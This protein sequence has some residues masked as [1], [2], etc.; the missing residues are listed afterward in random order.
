[1]ENCYYRCK[2]LCTFELKDDMGFY[3]E[4]KVLAW[5]EAAAERVLTC[6]ECGA[7]VY[8]AAGTIKEPYFA[9][10]DLEDCDYGSGQESEELRK[11]KRLIYQLLRRSFP[12]YDIQARYRLEN[13][14][15]ASMFCTDGD[16]SIVIDY[17]LLNSS[18]Q[19][20]R[21]RDNYYQA[22][23]LTVVY[24]LGKRQQKDTKQLDW[25]QNLIQASAGCLA[26]LD[27]GEETLTLKRSIGYRL[28]KE[29]KFKY[30]VKSYKMAEVMLSDQGRFLCDFDEECHKI[31]AEAEQEK[32]LYQV[33]QDNL[34]RLQ[35]ERI[36][37][38]EQERKRME[39]YHKKQILEKAKKLTEAQI[40][41]MELNP[42]LF[43]KCVSM[44]E[45]GNGHLVAKKY[46]D[47]ING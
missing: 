32:H 14:M 42:A 35:E 29:R 3:Y 43:Y 36:Q 7:P 15:Y 28:G 25:Y 20:F 9:H 1:M 34:R 2:V 27:P 47:K 18:L 24:I 16:H 10:Y 40:L 22:S 41:A 17:R 46:Y 12:E 6:T 26:F 19:K 38:E 30:C 13:G 4:D 21:E 5:K 8:L 37:L 44:I 31:E 11:G 23:S 33:R 45:E 39:A